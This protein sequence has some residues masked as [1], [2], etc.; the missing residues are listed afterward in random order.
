[1]KLSELL[2]PGEYRSASDAE[3]I[4]VRGLSCHTDRVEPGFLFICLR[5]THF[6]SRTLIGKIAEAGACAVITEY[7]TLPL[8]MASI[9]VFEVKNARAALATVYSRF[10]KNPADSMTVIGI[11]GTN[12][13][14]STAAILYG[15]LRH[16]GKHAALIGTVDCLI[17]DRRYSL[18]EEEG[19]NRLRT[20][21]T[22]DPDILYPMLARMEDE[23]TE[24]VVME[25]SS[26]ALALS[27]V[28]PIRFKLAVFTNLSPE[29]L[30]FHDTME[31]YLAAKAVLFR[32]ADI[33]IFNGDDLYAEDLIATSACRI[34]R[35]GIIWQ[36]DARATDIV[37]RGSRGVSYTYISENARMRVHLPLPGDFS[38]CNSLLA[39]QAATELGLRPSDILPALSE[40][41]PVPGRLERLPLPSSAD[42][43]VFID[44]AHTEEALR[45]LLNSVRRFRQHD[46]RIVLL[47]GCGGD[48]DRTKRA[49]MGHV[50]EE[51]SD[52]LIITSDNS[53]SEDPAAII[54]EIRAG[55]VKKEKQIV[56]KNRKSA[57]EYA[58]LNARPKDIILLCGKGHETYEIDRR[59]IR[60][61]DERE[62]V[63]AALEKRKNGD[64]VLHE[65]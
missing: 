64:T 54:A 55:T 22:P 60:H 34:V 5:G 18:P 39:L 44:Y 2:F 7:G 37:L 42:F 38:V 1:M 32:Q 47:F 3:T 9:P 52:F 53:R 21:T 28:S 43:S 41:R 15:I 50:A 46:E 24:Y 16:S 62:I 35:T 8:D 26:H 23:G 6:D 45:V 58:I 57:I 61:F 49:A 48:R 33:G 4:T 19:G 36:G 17:D 20:M 27:K 51:L 25:V 13:K 59:G 56:I 11:T 63:R 14:S 31:N 65:N 30:D 40:L 12:G 10:Y 29:H